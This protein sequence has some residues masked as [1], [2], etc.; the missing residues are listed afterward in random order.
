MRARRRS[1]VVALALALALALSVAAGCGSSGPGGS[2]PLYPSPDPS[3]GV[4]ALGTVVDLSGFI[5]A[6]PAGTRAEDKARL[7]LIAMIGKLGYQAQTQGFSVGSRGQPL[8]SANVVFTKPGD[9][10]RT[11][12]VGAHYDSVSVGQGAFDNATGVGVLLDA[13]RYLRDKR[14]PDTIAFVL[15]GA[16]EKGELGS[17]WYVKHLTAQQKKDVVCMVNLDS[18]ATGDQLYVYSGT[19][20]DGQGGQPHAGWPRD[21]VLAWAKQMGIPLTTSPGVNQ[22]YPAGTTGDWSDHKP[23]LKAGIPYLYFEATN[24]GLGDLDGYVATEAAGKVWHTRDDNLQ[25]IQKTFPGRLQT[26]LRQV[27]TL[28]ERFL[29]APEP[30]AAT[31]SPPASATRPASPTP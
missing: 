28:L 9:S 13:A 12:V 3:A 26:Q 2:V 24:W 17:T 19:P 8:V 1:A 25:F 30:P 20:L 18:V 15:F 21:E 27:T 10:A 22:D 23:F 5:G 7:A 16:E 14:T 29:A 11:I 31:P 6:R 4:A